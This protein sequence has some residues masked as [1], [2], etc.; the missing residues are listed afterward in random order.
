MVRMLRSNLVIKF[1]CEKLV[2][3]KFLSIFKVSL[4]ISLE[5]ISSLTRTIT[6]PSNSLRFLRKGVVK[7]GILNCPSGNDSSSLVSD[8]TKMATYPLI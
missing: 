6:P 4:G 1:S 5:G 3:R 8:M 7:P 2:Q